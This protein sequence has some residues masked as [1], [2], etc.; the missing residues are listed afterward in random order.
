MFSL[1]GTQGFIMVTKTLLSLNVTFSLTFNVTCFSLLTSLTHSW[2]GNAQFTVWLSF[3]YHGVWLP[4]L[5]R[6]QRK[7]KIP[8]FS[9]KHRWIQVLA[10]SLPVCMASGIQ[11]RQN[12]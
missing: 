2:P 1:G 3:P 11:I 7:G 10:L 9:T 12:T 6:G 8:N 5:R 4:Y